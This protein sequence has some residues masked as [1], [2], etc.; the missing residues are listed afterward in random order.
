MLEMM[1]QSGISH[2]SCF[3]RVP[4]MHPMTNKADCDAGGRKRSLR[5]LQFKKTAW[6][7]TEPHYS[8]RLLAEPVGSQHFASATVQGLEVVT[9]APK[10]PAKVPQARKQKNTLFPRPAKCMISCLS[11]KMILHCLFIVYH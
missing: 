1:I 11:T 6:N 8:W 4:Q 3:T 7:R 9:V 5:I 2:W 10:V